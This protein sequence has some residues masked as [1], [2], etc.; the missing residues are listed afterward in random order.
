MMTAD[1]ELP[2]WVYDD[3]PASSE[4]E[5]E[6]VINLATAIRRERA[7]SSNIGILPRGTDVAIARQIAVRLGDGRP[8]VFDEGALWAYRDTHWS[9]VEHH[10]LRRLVHQ[11]DG[12]PC[13]VGGDVKLSAARVSGVINELAAILTQ[14]GFFAD[15]PSGINCSSGFI[16]F[17]DEGIPT[18]VPHDPNHRQRHLLPGRWAPGAAPN[19]RKGSLLAKLLDGVFFGDPDAQEKVALLAEVAG[20]AAIGLATKLRSPRAIILHGPQAENGKS[21]ILELLRGLLP[22]T[23]ISAIPPSKLGVDHHKI[24]LVGKLLNCADELS[25]AAAVAGDDFKSF[26]TGDL[27]NGRDLYKS[28]RSFRPIAQHVFAANV[29]P[30][31]TGGMDRGV[32][33]RLL[34]IPFRRVIPS[35]ERIEQIGRRIATEEGDELLAWAV[36]GA[37]R[38]IVNRR[39]TEP[40]SSVKALREWLLAADPVLAWAAACLRVNTDECDGLTKTRTSDAH[41]SF[42][43][44]SIDQG[45]PEK[46]IPMVG[47]FT[48]RL[49]ANIS[50]LLYKRRRDGRFL[51]NAYIV[52]NDH[53][54]DA[55]GDDR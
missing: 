6:N 1:D 39:F 33:R 20:V 23:A 36:D 53:S 38:L 21:Q 48:K 17:G 18:I 24:A 5:G 11:Y 47:T 3:P 2:P 13:H 42:K 54:A 44:W 41:R 7:S 35:E 37:A 10:R 30:P 29:L 25:S 31:F 16:T 14:Q 12:A 52:A 32:Q 15:A 50:G 19:P 34:L 27:V 43:T 28:T 45:Y 22:P 26:V 55:D 46:T 4:F 51:W 49:T 40:A 8:T 9:E